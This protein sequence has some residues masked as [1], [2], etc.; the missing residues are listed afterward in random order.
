MCIY[1]Y[2]DRYKNSINVNESHNR[3]SQ[4]MAIN[5]S[6]EDSIMYT[7]QTKKIITCE[8]KLYLLFNV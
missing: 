4:K 8:C 1:I 6:K 7:I 2:I 5:V 3:K